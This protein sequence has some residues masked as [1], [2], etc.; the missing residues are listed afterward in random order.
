M[1]KNA[2]NGI[3]RASMVAALVCGGCE[4]PGVSE[5]SLP[6]YA[7]AIREVADPKGKKKEKKKEKT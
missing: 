4:D 7:K 5:E 6:V 1:K 2:L 3:S